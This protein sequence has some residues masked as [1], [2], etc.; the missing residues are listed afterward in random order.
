MAGICGEIKEMWRS[1]QWE[2]GVIKEMWQSILRKRRNT[3]KWRSQPQEEAKY[4][5]KGTKKGK[6]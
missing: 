5:E 6:A 4:W 2:K 3:K 1:F